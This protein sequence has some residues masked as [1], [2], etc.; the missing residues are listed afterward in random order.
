MKKYIKHII[1]ILILF[2]LS[3]L[4]FAYV[5]NEINL[6]LKE[7]FYRLMHLLTFATSVFIYAAC[8]VNTK[9]DK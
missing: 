3:Y 6:F 1:S 2:I 8:V 4:C 7:E 9:T 5:L